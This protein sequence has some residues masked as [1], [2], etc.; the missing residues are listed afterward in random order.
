MKQFE[1]TR[2]I[3]APADKTFSVVSDTNRLEQWLPPQLHDKFMQATA[4][5]GRRYDIAEHARPDRNKKRLSWDDG[6]GDGY[7]GYVQV[8]DA[9]AE[10]DVTIHIDAEQ[11]TT[12]QAEVDR[13]FQQALQGLERQVV[14]GTGPAYPSRQPG[15]G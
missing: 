8:K 7:S 1:Q 5:A 11:P 2:H 13:L 6:N 4:R 14:V 15:R 10:C 9:G 12:P 3:K